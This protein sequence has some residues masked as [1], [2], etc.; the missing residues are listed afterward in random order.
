MKEIQKSITKKTRLK[1]EYF[2]ALK[3]EGYA[4]P[5]RKPISQAKTNVRKLREEKALQGKQKLDEKKEMK[6]ERK[7]LQKEQ[8]EERRKREL[9]QIKL[10]KDKYEQREKRKVRMTQRTR[11][12]QP[13][14]G[15]KI[16]D[17][18]DK[19]KGDETYTR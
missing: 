6:R 7:K 19:I 15:P 5:E 16:N 4:V 14:M 17:L 12:G 9:D 2:K 11:S 10:S 3:E 1:K 18:L 13:R 8:V